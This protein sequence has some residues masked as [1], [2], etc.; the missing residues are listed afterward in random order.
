MSL[1]EIRL[2]PVNAMLGRSTLTVTSGPSNEPEG[3]ISL[4][5]AKA[6]VARGEAAW[7]GDPPP[8]HGQTKGDPP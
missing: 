8:T 6:L 4:A 2:V 1:G 5:E 7:V 3:V